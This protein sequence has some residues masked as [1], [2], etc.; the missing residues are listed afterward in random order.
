MS[1]Y[2]VLSG[3][4][5]HIREKKSVKIDENK[6]V[7]DHNWLDIYIYIYILIYIKFFIWNNRQ[8][9]VVP[10][11]VKALYSDATNLNS[12]RTQVQD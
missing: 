2:V 1:T 8:S 6:T 7:I 11:T 9:K 10:Y 12:N 5:T 4:E 3:T